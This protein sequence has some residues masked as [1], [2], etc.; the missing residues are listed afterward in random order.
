MRGVFKSDLLILTPESEDERAQFAAWR[1][2]A[3]G[4]VFYF[5]GGSAKGG[6]LRDLGLRED[7]CREPI[8]IVYDNADR[9]QPISNLAATP[10]TLAGR[11]YAS[12]EG[13]WQGLK[14]DSE[15]ERRHVATLSGRDAKRA[16][17]KG[18]APAT[19]S[20]Q[21]R[22]YLAGSA[23]HRALMLQACRAKFAQHLPARQALLS[24]G[25]RPLMHRVRRDSKTIPGVVMADIWMRIRS[26][27]RRASEQRE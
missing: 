15:D 10:F 26:Q 7:A 25:E 17:P 24:T 9:W 3:R 11:A 4:H 1:E 27:L 5:D 12:V 20:Y 2:T 14:F 19:F 18:P 23:D 13:F 6:A 21:G 22:T 16:A 8:N